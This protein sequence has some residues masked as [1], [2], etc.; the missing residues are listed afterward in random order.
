M[1]TIEALGATAV[2]IGSPYDMAA[3]LSTECVDGCFT[4]YSGGAFPFGLLD[5]TQYNTEV[6][7]HVPL[8]VLAMNKAKYENLHPA[9][10]TLLDTFCG[11]NES[12]SYAETHYASTTYYKTIVSNWRASH[13]QPPIYVLP[14]EELDN[15][16]AACEG[17]AP[18]W[19]GYMDGPGFDGQ[20]IYDRAF[21]LITEYEASSS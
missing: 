17:V 18:D 19:V 15:W 20:G 8:F 9:A 14:Q 11:A 12:A 21:E 1:P 2:E 5:V 13:G 16:K 4:Y 7:L 3:A 10:K 6:N